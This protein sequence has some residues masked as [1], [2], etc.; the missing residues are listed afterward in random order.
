MGGN[1]RREVCTFR[2]FGAWE[3]AHEIPI[4]ERYLFKKLHHLLGQEESVS[5][6]L[7]Y[8][9]TVPKSEFLSYIQKALMVS[10]LVLETT[11]LDSSSKN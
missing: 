10:K 1:Y 4:E 9:D 8:T 2:W 7:V 5:D 11:N 6:E 3:Q